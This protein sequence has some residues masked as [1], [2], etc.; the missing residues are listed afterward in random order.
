M[1]GSTKKS[2]LTAIGIVMLLLCNAE[3]QAL[4]NTQF[5]FQLDLEHQEI[6]LEQNSQLQSNA[7]GI[8][9]QDR[10]GWPIGLD[11]YFGYMG[12]SH[13]NISN[14]V[15]IDTS[16]YYLGLGISSSTS[17]EKTIQT[18]VDVSYVYY[19]GTDNSTG[20]SMELKWG[21]VDGRAWL[22][23]NISKRVKPYICATYLYLN[24]TQRVNGTSP[25][26][27]DLKNKDDFGGCAGLVF[28]MPEKGFIGIEAAGGAKE[29]VKVYFGKSFNY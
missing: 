11:L 1:S 25:S 28:T 19:A 15:A 8:R 9:Y 18:G 20:N 10:S 24:G 27:T 26:Q 16:G 3:S 14:T 21:Q 7:I 5:D 6:D 13:D 2:N 22:M 17:A 29:G 23:A 4:T 12:A